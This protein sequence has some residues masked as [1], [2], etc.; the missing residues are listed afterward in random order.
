MTAEPSLPVALV[1]A[2]MLFRYALEASLYV[3]GYVAWIVSCR[4]EYPLTQ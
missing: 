4:V 1:R 3:G 2:N